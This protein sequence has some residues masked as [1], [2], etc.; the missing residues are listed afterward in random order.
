MWMKSLWEIVFKQ[1]SVCWSS[2]LDGPV[3]NGRSYGCW[4]WVGIC[5]SVLQRF[6][7]QSISILSCQAVTK[8]FW[9]SGGSP[10]WFLCYC[11]TLISALIV[12]FWILLTRWTIWLGLWEHFIFHNETHK[13]D[14]N[15]N[16][17]ITNRTEQGFKRTAHVF[18]FKDLCHSESFGRCSRNQ[19]KF[20][21]PAVKWGHRLGTYFWWCSCSSA[22]LICAS[23][24]VKV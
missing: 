18:W 2:Y 17:A 22:Q 5:K 20:V 3:M 7:I 6:V 16:L 9:N 24:T 11:C 15:I 10:L 23:K 13:W 14:D 8:K 12:F 1:S 21:F 4:S 19:C